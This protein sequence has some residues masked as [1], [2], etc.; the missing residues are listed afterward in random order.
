M[1]LGER[2]EQTQQEVNSDS[3]EHDVFFSNEQ[4]YANSQQTKGHEVLV[5]SSKASLSPQAS[6]PP[7]SRGRQEHSPWCTEEH[8]KDE[9]N[10]E[11]AYGVT[12]LTVPVLIIA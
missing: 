10:T 8:W 12:S 9:R 3:W 4:S 7:S 5:S 1:Y 2:K 6:N 11:E